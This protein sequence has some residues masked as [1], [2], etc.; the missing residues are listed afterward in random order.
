VTGGQT[1]GTA[2]LAATASTRLTPELASKAAIF[3]E[4][5]STAISFVG[6]AGQAA[7]AS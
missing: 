5:Q 1:P 3:P 2:A 6:L 4:P 7:E